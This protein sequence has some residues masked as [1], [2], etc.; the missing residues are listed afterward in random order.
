MSDGCNDGMNDK[1]TQLRHTVMD[2]KYLQWQ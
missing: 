1:G 2:E